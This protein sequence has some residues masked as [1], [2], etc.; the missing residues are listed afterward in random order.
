MKQRV[1][2]TC[3]QVPEARKQQPLLIPASF[4]ASGRLQQHLEL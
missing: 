4:T 2:I 3:K 1:P